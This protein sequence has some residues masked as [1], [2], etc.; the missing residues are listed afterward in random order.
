MMLSN[1]LIAVLALCSGVA[2]AINGFDIGN[3]N[4][5]T[6]DLGTQTNPLDALSPY[7]LR[8]TFPKNCITQCGDFQTGGMPLMLFVTG[9]A[10]QLAA[11]DYDVIAN[12]IS[13]HG[14]IVVMCDQNFG[15]SLTLDYSTL[16][17]NLQKVI[18]FIRQSGE[19]GFLYQLQLRGFSNSIYGGGARMFMAGHSSGAH[20]VLQNI[21]DYAEAS[22]VCINAGGVIMLSPMDGEDPLGFGGGYVVNSG[23]LLPFSTPAL[24]IA[25]SL[26]GASGPVVAGAPCTPNDRGDLHF[27]DAW[28]GEINY[29]DAQGMGTLDVLDEASTT[30]Y[31]Q[32]CARSN[33][34]D[35]AGRLAYRTM[36]RGAIVSFIEG[37]IVNDQSD[38]DLLSDPTELNFDVTTQQMGN[39]RAYG[40]TYVPVVQGLSSE[41]QTGLILFGF[42][43]AFTFLTGLYCFFRRMDDD[44]LH[45]YHPAEGVGYDQAA[46][47]RTKLEPKY[48]GSVANEHHQTSFSLNGGERGHPPS[49]SPS[50]NV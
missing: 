18:G 6:F 48:S 28:V 35:V 11:S 24:L 41:V 20:V 46:S 47:F 44:T 34:S 21:K 15:F 25:A 31:D 36:V 32:F 14:I 7:H 43:F 2:F 33:A 13:R 16:G 19:N 30:I 50:I 26:D 10:G 3:W 42:L 27:Y 45:R 17:Q 12:G 40:C 4:P 23:Q 37:I 5:V 49:R 29:I 9:F 39:G 38:I 22:G 1:I 8:V